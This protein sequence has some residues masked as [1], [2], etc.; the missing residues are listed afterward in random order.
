MMGMGEGCPTFNI[1]LTRENYLDL[2]YPEG[3]PAVGARRA[4]RV[5]QRRSVKQNKFAPFGRSS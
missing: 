5:C 4:R 2:A 3:L 1:P